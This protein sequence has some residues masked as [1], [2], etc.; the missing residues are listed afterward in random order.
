M[1]AKQ[2]DEPTAATLAQEE[3]EVGE[4]EE[5]GST[6]KLCVK[7]GVDMGDPQQ[8]CGKTRCYYEG[9]NDQ[10]LSQEDNDEL[11]CAEAMDEEGSVN[12]DT[13]TPTPSVNNRKRKHNKGFL[14]TRA[15]NERAGDK[16]KRRIAPIKKW[17]DMVVNEVYRVYKVHDMMV[18]INGAQQLSHYGEFE[19]S[20]IRLTNAWLTNII[21]EE[22]N[23]HELSGGN[24]FLKPLG[25]KKAI[26]SGNQYH[27]FVI[28][29][30]E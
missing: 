12:N 30:D 16:A 8:L 11:A 26:K 15:F 5:G 1:A 13:P 28:V 9:D 23:K 25:K 29:V 14:S 7:R 22:L 10:K 6:K 18:T 19:D 17:R 20:K 21:Y 27:D 2:V 24:V 3:E 4:M